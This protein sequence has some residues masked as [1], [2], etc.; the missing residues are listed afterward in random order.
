MRPFWLTFAA[1]G[2]LAA[3]PAWAD[4]VGP[5][6]S[7]IG[8]SVSAIVPIVFADG[9]VIVVGVGPRVTLNVTPGLA[10]EALAEVVGPFETSATM[11]LHQVQLK[12][13]LRKSA[14]RMRTLSLTVGAAGSASYQHVREVRIVRLDGST[15]VYPEYRRSHA[16]V[17]G[18]LALGIV[19][20]R[21]LGRHASSRFEAQGYVGAVGGFALRAAAGLS[22]GIGAYR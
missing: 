14:D 16:T 18:T 2:M 11:A 5:P 10:V 17:P 3:S 9:P 6:R 20:E 12:V 7:E 21:V 19:R 15:V 4:E 22:F 1:A 13:T 8:G